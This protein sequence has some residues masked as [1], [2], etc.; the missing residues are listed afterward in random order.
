MSRVRLTASPSKSVTFKVTPSTPPFIN[1]TSSWLPGEVSLST[2]LTARYC[3]IVTLPLPSIEKANT[4]GPAPP[5]A[6][7]R[8]VP[9]GPATKVMAVLV[10][11]SIRPVAPPPVMVRLQATEPD[12]AGP[13]AP[14]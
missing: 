11:V 8:T 7:P 13:S 3:T 2:W 6:L 10:A 12:A 5:L 1:T 9:F 14:N 4:T